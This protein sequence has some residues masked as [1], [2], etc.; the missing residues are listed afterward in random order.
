MLFHAIGNYSV[1]QEGSRRTANTYHMHG[2]CRA[3]KYER[4]QGTEERV[5]LLEF[6]MAFFKILTSALFDGI[7]RC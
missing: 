3:R 1:S 5:F 7:F 6:I 2:A 4:K